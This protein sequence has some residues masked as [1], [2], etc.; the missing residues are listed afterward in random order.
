[1]PVLN[2]CAAGL[3]TLAILLAIIYAVRGNT[4]M[5]FN[6][7][8]TNLFGSNTDKPAKPDDIKERVTNYYWVAIVAGLCLLVAF[9]LVAL[10]HAQVSGQL[11]KAKE[12]CLDRIKEGTAKCELSKATLGSNVLDI[13][14][15]ST[16]SKG[17]IGSGSSSSRGSKVASPGSRMAIGSNTVS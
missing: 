9:A 14:S 12:D 17:A 4:A 6:D 13:L 7:K 10:S 8:I 15:T 16:G 5:I 3:I 2:R 1:M 11:N